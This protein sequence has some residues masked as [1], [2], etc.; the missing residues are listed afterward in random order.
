MDALKFIKEAKRMCE[1]YG[2]GMCKDP[3]KK[4]VDCSYEFWMQ[5]V[6]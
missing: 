1:S 5:E 2:D 6:E 3:R 4:C